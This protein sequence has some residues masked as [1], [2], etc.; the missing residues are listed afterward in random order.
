METSEMPPTY[1]RTNKFTRGFQDIVDAYGIAAY[2][3]I[4][5]GF[6][7]TKTY[8]TFCFSAVH[9]DFF[10]IFVCIDVWRYGTR[11]FN[12]FVGIV[13]D[14]EGKAIGSSAHQG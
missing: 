12:V 4:N 5:P 8:L 14:F 13:L 1:H 3:E 2:R 7:T 10:P 9:N 6:L 11:N